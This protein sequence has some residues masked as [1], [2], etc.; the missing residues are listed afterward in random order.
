[1]RKYVAALTLLVALVSGAV[2]VAFQFG[3]DLAKQASA[4]FVAPTSANEA[5]NLCEEDEA[6]WNWETMGN[7]V[8]GIRPHGKF[9]YQTTIGRNAVV[10]LAGTRVKF[11]YGCY[12][13]GYASPMVTGYWCSSYVPVKA[14]P[15]ERPKPVVQ[16]KYVTKYRTKYVTKNPPVGAV[17]THTGRVVKA[18][19]RGCIW[20]TAKDLGRQAYTDPGDGA[21]FCER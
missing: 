17:R 15:T 11:P 1:M 3:P 5:V 7:R 12:E 2:G 10:N 19:Y 6:C 13:G 4:S 21:W 9:V 8:R 16:K 20:L 18:D 14:Q